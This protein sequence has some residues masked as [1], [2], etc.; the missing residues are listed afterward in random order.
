MEKFVYYITPSSFCR[1]VERSV[2]RL[3]QIID[4][5]P[6]K[7]IYCIHAIVHNPKLTK[8]FVDQGVIFVETIEE[9]SNPDAIVTFSAHGINRFILKEAQERFAEVYNLECPL[10]TKIYR[11]I[12]GYMKQEIYDFLYIGKPTHQEAKNVTDYILW[13]WHQVTIIQKIEEIPQ[14]RPKDKVFAVLSQTTLNYS[15]VKSLDEEI[16]ALFPNARFGS[17]TDICKA[18]YERQA[19][20]IQFIDRYDSLVV[21]WGKESHNT[22]ELVKLWER[23]NKHT[24]YAETGQEILEFWEDILMKDALVA[25]TW[26]AST[27]PEDI[28]AVF[29]WYKSQWYEQKVLTFVEPDWEYQ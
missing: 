29:D 27:P 2:D 20:L 18:T 4:K 5:N 11:E 10:V 13:L 16:L 22:Y 15:H 26:W 6:W 3:Q 1:W 12:S 24:I 23:Y 14:D 17:L 7:Q 25:V 21:I 19:A 28:R 9:I 8:R